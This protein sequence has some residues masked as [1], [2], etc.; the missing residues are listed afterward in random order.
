MTGCIVLMSLVIIKLT[1]MCF[2]HFDTGTQEG[3][4]PDPSSSEQKD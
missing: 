1:V 4:H 3:S 2:D